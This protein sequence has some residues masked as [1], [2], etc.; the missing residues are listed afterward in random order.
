MGAPVV[1]IALSGYYGFD[2]SGDEAVLQSILF[3]LQEQ[4]RSRAF[5]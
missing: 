1:K 3:A 4:G 2:N 5:R